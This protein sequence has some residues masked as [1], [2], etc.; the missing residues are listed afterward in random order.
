MLMVPDVTLDG[1][2][3]NAR[4]IHVPSIDELSGGRIRHQTLLLCA[5]IHN[6]YF[7]EPYALFIARSRGYSR[8]HH[9]LHELLGF[10]S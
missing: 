3:S 10:Y 6:L 4:N 7:C 9:Q 8:H 1:R 2:R 5:S